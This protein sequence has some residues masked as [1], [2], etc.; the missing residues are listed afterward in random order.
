MSE[1]P[2]C[3]AEA[4]PDSLHCPVARATARF[5]SVWDMMCLSFGAKQNGPVHA[6]TIAVWTGPEDSV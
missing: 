3:V 4:D 6:A 2:V 1:Q 5:T